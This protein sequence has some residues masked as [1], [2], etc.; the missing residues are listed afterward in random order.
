MFFLFRKEDHIMHMVLRTSLSR[1]NYV[2]GDLYMTLTVELLSSLETFR[3][4]G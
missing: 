4:V 1:T 2:L 3:F